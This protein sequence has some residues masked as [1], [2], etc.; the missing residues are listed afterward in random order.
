MYKRI[1]LGNVTAEDHGSPHLV[2]TGTS[3]ARLYQEGSL[4][5]GKPVETSRLK[6]MQ[7]NSTRPRTR[8]YYDN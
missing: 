3:H 7:L 4:D 6:D 1:W 8:F 2:E 5:Y